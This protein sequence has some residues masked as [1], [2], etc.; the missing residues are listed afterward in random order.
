MKSVT[1]QTK[2]MP[3][4]AA[5]FLRMPAVWISAA[6]FCA[7]LWG[8]AFP[9]I[10][11]GYELFQIDTNNVY[12]IMAFAGTRFTIAGLLTLVIAIPITKSIPKVD[13]SERKGIFLLG[14]VQTTLQY[15]FFYIALSN[16]SGVNGSIL[17]STSGFIAVLFAAMYYANDRLTVGKIVGCLMGLAGVVL[18]NLGEGEISAT[19]S[20]FGEGFMLI[21]A[22]LSALG[23]LMSKELT[24]KTGPFAVSG[25]QLLFGGLLLAVIGFVGGGTLRPTGFQAYLLMSYLAFLSCAAFGIW[26]ILLKH[27]PLSKISIFKVTIP[28]FGSFLSIVLLGEPLRPTAI[29]S[30]LLIVAGIIVLNRWKASKI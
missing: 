22:A 28:I 5:S 19:F 20:L 2:E 17:S 27:H 13:K 7:L 23:A 24:G 30:L 12:A 10:K 9:A 14:L 29:I 15:T 6:L 4:S 26:T 18:L 1:S 25:Y 21:S 8:S 11:T 16:T 3:S